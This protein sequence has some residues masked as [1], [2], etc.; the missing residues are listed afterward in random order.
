M[1]L[2]SRQSASA[3]NSE[4]V[5]VVQHM[6]PGGIE[7]L[8]LDLVGRS[9]GNDWILSL[10]GT[11][12]SLCANWP[13]LNAVRSRLIGLNKGRGF[14]L[15][16]IKRLSDDMRAT[17][18]RM[19][20][21]HHIGPLIYAGAAAR[22]AGV[23]RIVHVEH[24][25]W[26]Y[27]SAKARYYTRIAS[28]VIRPR[29]VAVSNAGAARLKEIVPGCDVTVI[30]PA[31]DTNRFR[32]ADRARARQNLGFDDTAR[33]I[34]SAGRLVAVKG[35]EVLIDALPLLPSD[36]HVV[37]AGDGP[38]RARLIERAQAL[39]VSDRLH[40]LGHREDLEFILPAF[41]VF[42]LPSHNEG[43][44]RTVLEAQACDLPVVASDVGAMSEAVCASTGVLVPAADPA[45]FGR[46]LERIRRE[47]TR[48]GEAR[49]F[50][51]RE[52]GW[53]RTL[54]AY[55]HLMER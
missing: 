53:A 7:T 17:S 6:A 13:A 35:H 32:P 46:A 51:E 3:R 1:F 14:S 39:G 49:A 38:E 48:T 44:P 29:H 11:P 45:A 8:V 22:L 26:H 25:V 4:T 20:V 55:K 42:C 19:V 15:S 18:P 30:P 24:D 37:I 34:G 28:A 23:P 41:D 47:E 50:V 43:L 21:A 40:L 31:I 16:L 52:Y 5:H 9:G 12:E 33:L 36:T 10:E 54:D 2:V 27:A